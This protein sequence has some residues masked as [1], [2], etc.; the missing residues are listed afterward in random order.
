MR[1]S[2]VSCQ[3]TPNGKRKESH[4]TTVKKTTYIKLMIISLGKFL[5]IS[6]RAPDFSIDPGI[7]IITLSDKLR[8]SLRTIITYIL[9]VLQLNMIPFKC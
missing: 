9:K 6:F 1:L 2:I 4:E 5:K 8:R 7:Q 3:I